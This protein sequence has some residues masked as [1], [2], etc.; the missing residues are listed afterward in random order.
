M[1]FKLSFFSFFLRIRVGKSG[2]DKF[3]LVETTFA[4][5]LRVQRHWNKHRL[6]FGVGNFVSK[7]CEHLHSNKVD[8]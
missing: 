4:L 2:C 1:D 8:K 3:G 7:G 6:Q 5:T